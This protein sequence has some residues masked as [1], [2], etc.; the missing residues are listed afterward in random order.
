M[1]LM[2]EYPGNRKTP[3][4]REA[5]KQERVTTG[6]VIRKKPGL[7]R[8]LASAF[9]GEDGRSVMSHVVWD[10][11]IPAAKDMIADAGRETIE[12]ALY[13]ES[14]GRSPRTN[15]NAIGYSLASRVNYNRPQQDNRPRPD[16]RPKTVTTRGRVSIDDIVLSS[17][18]EASEVISR[19]RA[20][21]SEYGRATVADLFDLVGVTGEYTDEKFGWV[22]LENVRP[23][24]I[25]EG[26]LLDLPNPSQVD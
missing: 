25:R 14:R 16:Q 8:R 13:G 12:R 6:E 11:L 2:D 24:R 19:L 18:A 4:K 7:G 21:V 1:S 17:H 22:S 5:P 3:P 15:Y 26:Y 20:L 9:T 10:V 23:R